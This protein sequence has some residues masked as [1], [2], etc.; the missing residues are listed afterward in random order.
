M[1][2]TRDMSGGKVWTNRISYNPW[3][4][5]LLYILPGI[6]LS[7]CLGVATEIPEPQ[8]AESEPASLAPVLPDSQLLDRAELDVAIVQDSGSEWTVRDFSRPYS[9]ISL[10]EMLRNARMYLNRQDV[11]EAERMALLIS[12]LARLAWHQ[13]AGNRHVKPVY[14][15]P[16]TNDA[17]P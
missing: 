8:P 16:V 6:M 3:M 2:Q 5:I 13:Q 1:E 15:V 7:G 12:R 4:R 9:R 10:H 11:E 14:P 17:E